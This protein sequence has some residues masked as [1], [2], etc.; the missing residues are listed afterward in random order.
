M[1]PCDNS[2]LPETRSTGLIFATGNTKT[3]VC[4]LCWLTKLLS[5]A[6]SCRQNSGYHQCDIKL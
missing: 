5:S 3:D 1:A 4:C 2:D 6:A